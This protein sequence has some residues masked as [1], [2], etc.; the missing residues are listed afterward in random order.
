MRMTLTLINEKPERI[1]IQLWTDRFDDGRFVQ[2]KDV[3]LCLPFS[4]FQELFDLIEKQKTLLEV[5]K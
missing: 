5:Q 2:I 1:T 4:C 3:G